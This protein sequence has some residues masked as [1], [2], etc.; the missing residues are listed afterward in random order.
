[1]YKKIKIEDILDIN[2]LNKMV[3]EKYISKKPNDSNTL[4]IY[5]YTKMTQ[6]DKVWNNETKTCR[7]L[8]VDEN[9]NIIARPFPKF[10]NLGEDVSIE[11]L[12]NESYK[13]TEKMDGS[14]G[15]MY[16]DPSNNQ[17]KIA[18]RGSFNSD[19]SI[20]ATKILN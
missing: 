10:F 13:I 3:E 2:N 11:D 20:E 14:L 6:F 18:T 15:I 9:N 17:F 1:M 19:Q 8:I 16:V 4:F 7:G 12:P 5:N